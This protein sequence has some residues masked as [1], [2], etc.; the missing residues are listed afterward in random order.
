MNKPRIPARPAILPMFGVDDE[1]AA[2]FECS[3]HP[4]AECARAGDRDARDTLY[5]VFEPKIMR[6]AGSIHSF[7]CDR[8][9]VAQEA[10]LAFLG[11]VERWPP[12]IPFGRY[13]LAH[14]PWRLRDAVHRGIGS[15]G[16]PT[17]FVAV[18]FDAPGW[19]DTVADHSTRVNEERTIIRV[20]AASFEAPLAAVVRMH[21]L[22]GLTLTETAERLGMSRRTATRHWRTVLGR[23]RANDAVADVE[24]DRWAA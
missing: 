22:D 9:D 21:I 23:L 10:Y 19:E 15:G 5:V 11:V 4:I 24:A 8:D 13:F 6:F 18:P 16:V 7:L 3:V 1:L 14:F 2:A 17:R 12:F 20:L